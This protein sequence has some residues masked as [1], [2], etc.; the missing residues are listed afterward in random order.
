MIVREPI[1]IDREGGRFVGPVFNVIVGD[2]SNRKSFVIHENVLSQSPT[3]ARM[4][5]STGYMEANN[6]TIR[7]PDDSPDTFSLL[8]EYLYS[9]DFSPTQRSVRE[10]AYYENHIWTDLHANLFGEL[11]VLAEKYMLSKLQDLITDKLRYLSESMTNQLLFEI[12]R[13]IY[14]GVCRERMTTAF[15]LWFE[16]EARLRI[17]G[18]SG[19]QWLLDLIEDGGPFARQ[20]GRTMASALK[21]TSPYF[22]LQ[23]SDRHRKRRRLEGYRGDAT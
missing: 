8:V 17:R 23:S 22:G 14:N 20:I 9:L 3:L 19:C 7:M 13:D 2:E 5:N 15:F 11:Y 12:A 16:V 18:A 6:L 4:C 21:E 10:S 1:D